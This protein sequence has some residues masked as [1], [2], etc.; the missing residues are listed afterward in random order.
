MRGGERR[1]NEHQRN[2]LEPV[3]ARLPD[4]TLHRCSESPAGPRVRGE[5][6]ISPRTETLSTH[7]RTCATAPPLLISRRSTAA[8]DARRTGTAT[9][10]RAIY[11]TITRP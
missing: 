3:G 11:T 4:R 1:T 10:V 5:S 2:W 7:A 6:R 9:A 8:R